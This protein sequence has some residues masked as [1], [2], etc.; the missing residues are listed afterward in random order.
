ML[1]P[2]PVPEERVIRFRPRTILIVIGIALAIVILL[3]IIWAARQVLTWIVI[4]AFLALALNPLVTLIQRRVRRRAL[5][6]ALAFLAALGVVA[7]VGVTLI[8]IL[9]T[10]VDDFAE[11][12]PGYVRDLVS[13]RGPLGFLQADYQIVDR[14]EEAVAEGGFGRLAGVSGFALAITRGVVTA[15]VAVITI[16]FLTFFMLLEGPGI[17]ERGYTLM[18]PQAE[19]R[20]RRIGREIYLTV[21]G[22]VT[23]ALTIAFI[24]GAFSAVLLSV[25]GIPYA[26]A[27]GL[28]AGLLSLVPLAG[29]T[30]AI[31]IMTTIAL[32]TASFPVALVVLVALVVYQQ[33]ENHVLYPLVYSRTVE[34]SPLV[35]LVAVLIGA[36]LG[37]IIGAIAAIPVAGTIQVLLREWLSHRQT[38]TG[39]AELA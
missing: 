24:A 13:G 39:P 36:S 10:E 34:L 17:V 29:A 7:A 8:P 31:V 35:I 25:L 14:I 27:L 30:I 23:G 3:Q 37:G 15:V 19:E 33:V 1:A 4:S 38:R 9:V 28:L 22:Y 5:A 21:G 11:A 16:A 18:S 26:I 12:L 32:L 20:W 2:V 6:S